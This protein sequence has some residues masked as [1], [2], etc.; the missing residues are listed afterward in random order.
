MDSVDLG[1][2]LHRVGLTAAPPATAPGLR[3]LHLAHA[4]HIPFENLDI[5]LGRPIKLDLANLQAKLIESNRGGYCFEQNLLFAR[6]LEQVGFPVTRL[7]A[8]VLYRATRVLPRTHMLIK[9]EAN[10][11]SWLA[12]VGFGGEGLLE[13]VPMVPGRPCPQFA[14]TYRVIENA[15]VWKLQSLRDGV[16]QDLYMFTLEPQLPVDYEPANHYVSTH[17]E[18]IFTQTMTVQLP[19]LQARYTLR[20][21][22]FTIDRGQALETR[23]IADER[24]RLGLLRDIFH[25]DFPDTARFE[26]QRAS[27]SSNEIPSRLLAR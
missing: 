10:G 17:P 27:V 18:S 12:D 16:W 11:S 4:T 15:G 23:S 20:N 19:T 3:E 26:S 21:E 24:E 6:I 13:P 5:L 22:V 14:W 9:V 25:L 7:A 1:R 8:R 2:Y